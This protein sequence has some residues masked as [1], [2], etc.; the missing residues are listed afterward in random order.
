MRVE[1]VG[2]RENQQ[3]RA[4]HIQPNVGSVRVGARV[5]QPTDETGALDHEAHPSQG[6][7]FS[8]V[9]GVQGRGLR[10]TSTII[11]F[12]SRKRRVYWREARV[13]NGQP[14]RR[15]AD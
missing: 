5:A 14:V 9:V 3:G 7:D 11:T 1:R 4:R 15:L 2:S 13:E 6:C 12:G 10:N 8:L